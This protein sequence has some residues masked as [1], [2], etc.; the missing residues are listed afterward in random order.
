MQLNFSISTV[1]YSGYRIEQAID[2]I[3]S[4]GVLNIEL[5]LIQGAVYDLTES[6]ITP[7]LAR[8]IKSYLDDKQMRC[9]S[10][11]AHCDLTL[12]NCEQ[13]LITRLEMCKI[14]ACKRLVLYAPRGAELGEFV[15]AASKAIALAKQ[16]GI[17]ILIENVG[18]TQAYLL[19]Q[20]DDFE[21]F[22]RQADNTVF[23][24]NFDP[25]NFLSHRPQLD[26]LEHSL[27]SLAFAEHLHLKD[28]YLEQDVWRCCELGGGAGKYQALLESAAAN[29][30]VPFFSIESPYA[31]ERLV[32]GSTRFKP[33]EQLLPIAEIEQRLSKSIEFINQCLA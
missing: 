8:W 22:C 19:N 11:A 7:E 14:L 33:R 9:S 32:D 4:L 23:G 27:S 15:I 16:L 17:K 26:V 18:D 20:A 5:A 6:D 25:G 29:E 28:L 31:L 12:E 30:Q 13:R 1:A 24:I 21:P 10:L 3:A 2:S